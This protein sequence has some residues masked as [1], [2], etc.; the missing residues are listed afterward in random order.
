MKKLRVLFSFATLSILLGCG[1]LADVH[2]PDEVNP[3][4]KRVSYTYKNNNFMGFSPP[5]NSYE[6]IERLSK[7]CERESNGKLSGLGYEVISISYPFV[8][9][10]EI[11]VSGYCCCLAEGESAGGDDEGDEGDGQKKSRRSRRSR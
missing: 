6:V 9:H 8:H 2:Y 11:T 10:L 1:G 7:K 3:V 5:E 4:G